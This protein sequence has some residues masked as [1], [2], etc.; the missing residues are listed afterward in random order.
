[1]VGTY[2]GLFYILGGFVNFSNRIIWHTYPVIRIDRL[3]ALVDM[4]VASKD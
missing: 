3:G 2:R 1:M 4:N